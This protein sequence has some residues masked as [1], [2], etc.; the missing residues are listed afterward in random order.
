MPLPWR[1]V[2]TPTA[3]G[4]AAPEGNAVA[5]LGI[6]GEGSDPA[7]A[8][9]AF[10]AEMRREYGLRP[11]R[12]EAVAVGEWPGY[13]VTF[14][15]VSARPAM[16]MHI[17]WFARGATTY[18]MIGLAPGSRRAEL[19]EIAKSLRPLTAEERSLAQAACAQVGEAL[20]RLRS[21]ERTSTQVARERALAEIVRKLEQAPDLESLMR[22]AADELAR[23]LRASRA[24]VHLGTREE[25][26]GS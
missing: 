25:L 26:S 8:A 20:A 22:T 18:Q 7:G 10:V 6:H 9:K 4:A 19:R 14:S 16:D 17:L 11:S 2:N 5:F 3:V 24:Y 1:T 12:S 13:V 15:D 23:A 21:L